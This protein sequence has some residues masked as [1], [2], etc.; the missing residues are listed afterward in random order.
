MAGLIGFTAWQMHQAKIDMREARWG[1]YAGA[2]DSEKIVVKFMDYRCGHCRD[3]HD[4]VQQWLIKYP[5]LKL[6]YRHYPAFGPPAVKEA[7]LVLAAGM[8][9]KFLP[10]HNILIR[11]ENPVT[12]ENIKQIATAFSLDLD[13]LLADMQSE[14]VTNYLLETWQGWGTLKLIATP[15]FMI[16]S[17]VFSGI[18]S[19]REFDKMMKEAYP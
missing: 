15:S 16:G 9:G 12:D 18:P 7:R 10:V 11:Q 14:D 13:Q 8:Q 19:M 4:D 17:K 2:E 6:V 3:A 5:D 1:T